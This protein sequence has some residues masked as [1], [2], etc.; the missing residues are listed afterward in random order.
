MTVRIGDYVAQSSKSVLDCTHATLAEIMNMKQ[1]MELNNMKHTLLIKLSPLMQ[2]R[3]GG[4]TECSVAS[5]WLQRAALDSCEPFYFSCVLGDSRAGALPMFLQSTGA[6]LC[7]KTNSI[8]LRDEESGCTQEFLSVTECRCC[9]SSCSAGP[10]SYVFSFPE[11]CTC[12]ASFT[13]IHADRFLS[14]L[15]SLH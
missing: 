14:L 8:N 4:G 5:V 15:R 9:V 2:M 7:R 1:H 13:H 12:S 6:Y 10:R 11:R 3:R